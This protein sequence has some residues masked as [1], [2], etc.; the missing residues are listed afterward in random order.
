MS[1][2]LGAG[3]RVLLGAGGMVAT[4]P[5]CCCGGCTTCGDRL[6]AV[7]SGT[8]G[9]ACLE[10]FEWPMGL[11]VVSDLGGGVTLYN[12]D[13]F[14]DG[15]NAGGINCVDGPPIQVVA[16][17]ESGGA[18]FWTLVASVNNI[19]IFSATGSGGFPLGT[20]IFN[21]TGAGQAIIT[22]GGV[23]GS[24]CSF[25]GACYGCAAMPGGLPGGM[26]SDQCTVLIAGLSGPGTPATFNGD[27]STCNPTPCAPGT[28][29]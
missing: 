15:G 2:M 20:P 4:D 7:F 12:W 29:C 16:Q 1:V 18:N 19:T 6:T 21:A 17:C 26:G 28:D 3:G 13:A 24:C 25:F 11:T 8:S 14:N 9:T 10:D 27:H 5:A 23:W 22:C